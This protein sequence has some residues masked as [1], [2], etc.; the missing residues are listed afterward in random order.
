MV[1]CC[2]GVLPLP[3]PEQFVSLAGAFPGAF[4]FWCFALQVM[5]VFWER[6]VV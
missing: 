2:L 4:Q 1:P 6:K 5:P 3:L